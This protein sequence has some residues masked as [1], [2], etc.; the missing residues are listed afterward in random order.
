M[1]SNKEIQ[2]VIMIIII[3]FFYSSYA[4]LSYNVKSFGAKSNGKSDCTKAF[5]S[6]A[7]TATKPAAIYVPLGRYLLRNA[8]FSGKL[9][10][11]TA[12]TIRIDGTLVFPNNYSVIGNSGTWLKFEKAS[13]VSIY[14][15]TLDGQG[16]VLWA[17]KN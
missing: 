1:I 6:A 9:C 15:G 2:I 14:G 10:K 5:L 13:G 12:I 17:C 3:F 16:A 11:N 8:V 4:T 7:C